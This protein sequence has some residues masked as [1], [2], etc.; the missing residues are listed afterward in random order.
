MP[1]A[2]DDPITTNPLTAADLDTAI[3]KADQWRADK[4]TFTSH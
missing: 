3:N 2:D 1:T 4:S